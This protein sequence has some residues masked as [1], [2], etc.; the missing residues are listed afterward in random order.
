MI[1]PWGAKTGGECGR[2][3]RKAAKPNERIPECPAHP[4]V[5]LLPI[6]TKRLRRH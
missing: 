2:L 6:H 5:M 3:R 1:C 4:Q